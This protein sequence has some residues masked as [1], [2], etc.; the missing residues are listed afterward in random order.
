VKEVKV[1]LK[2][3]KMDGSRRNDTSIAKLSSGGHGGQRVQDKEIRPVPSMAHSDVL[4]YGLLT[5]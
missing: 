2:H 5:S 1:M 4:S 3:N